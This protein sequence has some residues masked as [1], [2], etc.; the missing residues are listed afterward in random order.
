MTRITEQPQAATNASPPSIE[1][2]S[3]TSLR[4]QQV[5]SSLHGKHLRRQQRSFPHYE[6]THVLHRYNSVGD[7]EMMK[8]QLQKIINKRHTRALPVETVD[9]YSEIEHGVDKDELYIE[10]KPEEMPSLSSEH[11]SQTHKVSHELVTEEDDKDETNEI[12]IEMETEEDKTKL[13]D[14][15]KNSTSQTSDNTKGQPTI[16][17]SEENS[18]KEQNSFYIKMEPE[19]VTDVCTPLATDK[20]KQVDGQT[21]NNQ[22]PTQLDASNEQA[23]IYTDMEQ[24]GI[25]NLLPSSKDKRGASNDIP[26]QQVS[27]VSQEDELNKIYIEMEQDT[28]NLPRPELKNLASNSV[29]DQ[30]VIP[31][32]Q[33]DTEDKIYIEME[34]DDMS[35]TLSPKHHPPQINSDTPDDQLLSQGSEDIYITMH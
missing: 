32:N 34:P 27:P 31:V 16:V 19:G 33:E 20:D 21:S 13:P 12:Y 23:N 5:S 9:I 11:E 6:N 22:T 26:D 35:D 8:P 18:E 2:L 1:Q 30:P 24:E 14:D 29:L 4:R 7:Y 17:V 15:E 10:M 3:S 28:T 25:V